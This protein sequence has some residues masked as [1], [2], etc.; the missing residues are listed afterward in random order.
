MVTL[1]EDTMD[2]SSDMTKEVGK[3]R[4]CRSKGKDEGET[5]ESERRVDEG[6]ME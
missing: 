1:E 3:W 5:E 6:E 4:E 2:S